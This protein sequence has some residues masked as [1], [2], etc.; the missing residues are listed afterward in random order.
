MKLR[1]QSIYIL[2]T[3]LLL[4]A[5]QY[6]FP[7]S[8]V[9]E[10]DAGNADFSKY[11][12]VGNSLTAGL[13]D[14]ALYNRAQQHS[15][16]VILAGQL[17]AAG[18][19]AFNVPD[20]DSENGFF[21]MGPNGPLGRLILTTAPN[22]SISPAPIGPGE[23]PAPYTGDKASLNNFGVPGITLGQA[24]TPMTGG[25]ASEQ[26]PAY[27]P[28]YARFAS[29]PGQSTIIGDAAAALADG[30]TFFSFWLGSNDVLGYAIDGASN[31]NILTSNEDFQARLT[32]ALG[33]MLQANTAAF[34]VVLN[35]PPF[36][37]LPYF[38]LV[39]YNAVPLTQSEAD[40]ANQAYAL[41]NG[42]LQQ[43]AL[44]GLITEEER[45]YR[46]ITFT[47]GANAFVM[48]DESLTDLSALGLP[49]IRQST[50]EDKTTLP[51]AQALG[52]PSSEHPNGKRGV[53][54]P[55]EDEFML[56]PDEQAEVN[57]KIT[58]FNEMIAATVDANAERLVLVD[59]ASFIEQ[60]AAGQVNAGGV[61]L[62]ASIIP[63]N[64]GFSVDGV[65]PNG[66]AHAFLTNLVIDAINAKW[67]ANI[68]KVNPNAYVGNDLPR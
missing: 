18:G 6:E 36:N 1:N 12:A 56:I 37:H 62:N 43:A 10:P 45:Q 55:V 46:T 59:A 32:A 51:L 60:V 61:A 48:E 44:G 52:A 64:G 42:G 9:Q 7:E 68:L 19:G 15:F 8:P 54:F 40:Q 67:E 27:S 35:I 14:G 26:N 3:G 50:A 57:A 47:A 33:T 22:G 25:P 17:E 41:Y 49:P 16:A 58:S 20:I 31:P 2:L 13:M 24:L 34:G 21:S 23:I 63:P 30:G 29:A 5:C 39:P 53:T 4:G 66:R 38:N 28:L 65:H 11:V